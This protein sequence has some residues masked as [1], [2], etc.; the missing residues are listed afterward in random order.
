MID[1]DAYSM[2]GQRMQYYDASMYYTDKG[3]QAFGTARTSTLSPP[4]FQID[5]T[6]SLGPEAESSGK[7]FQPGFCF[8]AGH[9]QVSNYGYQTIA[10]RAVEVETDVKVGKDGGCTTRFLLTPAS[11]VGAGVDPAKFDSRRFW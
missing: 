2:Y 8:P 11:G 3:I 5:V 9:V 7:G 10:W 6:T 4:A 1:H